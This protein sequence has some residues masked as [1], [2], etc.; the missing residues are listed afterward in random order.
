MSVAAENEYN[1]NNLYS[2]GPHPYGIALLDSS[3]VHDQAYDISISLHVPRSPTNLDAGNFML[4]LSLLSPTYTPPALSIS[5]PSIQKPAL[6]STI[7][8]S[9]ILLASRRPALI[10]YRSRVVSLPARILAM[11]LYLLGLKHESETL[12][13]PMA[14]SASFQRGYKN[15][16]ARLLLEVQASSE[17]QVYDVRVHFTA[18]FAGLRWLMYNHRILSFMIFTTAFWIAELL[19]AGLG[20][21]GLRTYLMPAEEAQIVK[22]ERRD[23]VKDE[24]SDEHLSDVPRT[25]T[26]TRSSRPLRRGPTVKHEGSE[27][28]GLDELDIP[29][30]GEGPDGEEVKEERTGLV[31][32][33][34]GAT[35]SATGTSFSESSRS[36]GLSRR[37][38]RGG[39]GGVD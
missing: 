23:S 8:I 27:D 39:H 1:A 28:S 25:E 4:S 22:D 33:A 9:S 34:G 15:L 31:G 21:V 6:S 29:Q 3:I 2:D 5:P 30:V 38:S 20:W 14:E 11:P 12:T 24:D 7:P 35:D 18:R 37:R 36:P 13:I 17:V 32:L 16:P 26:E 19:F 10:P